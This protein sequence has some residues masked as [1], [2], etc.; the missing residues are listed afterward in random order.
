MEWNGTL[1]R[2]D[3]WEPR[4]LQDFI[5]PLVDKRVKYTD[6]DKR[7]IG[8]H[9]MMKGSAKGAV[10]A[11]QADYP[12]LA[13]STV[14][15]WTKTEWFQE[16]LGD[17]EQEYER[18]VRGKMNAIIEA[19]QNETLD[20]LH[21]GDAVLGKD[22][23]IKRVPMRGKDA[24]TVGAIAVDKRWLSLGKPTA[25]T[26]NAGTKHLEDLAKAFE[27]IAKDNE[28]REIR[29]E[30]AILGECEEITRPEKP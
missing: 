7:I 2:D 1:V 24:M 29:Q 11:A 20:R 6:E 16:I 30:T 13:V 8:L 14:N 18:R 17:C 10:K 5:R 21:N 22:G 3:S 25:I 23:E 4:N 19:A 9:Y 27:K 26:N 28:Y 15:N 12:K